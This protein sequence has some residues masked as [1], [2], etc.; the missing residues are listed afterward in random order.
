MVTKSKI[1]S[2]KLMKQ[3][4]KDALE[5]ALEEDDLYVEEVKGEHFVGN[6]HGLTLAGLPKRILELEQQ[7]T[8]FTSHRAKVASLEDHVGSL[9]TSIEA[10]KLLRNR[11][12]STFKRDK[13]LVNATEA[14]RKIIAEGNGWAHG[15]DVVVDALLYQGTEGRRDRLAF[16]KL[17]GI[18]P[19]D[20]RVISYQPTIDILNLHAGVIAS[21][22]KTGSDEFYARF[23]EFVK[24]LKESNY[25]KGYLEGNA[26][27]MT[28]AY[29]SFLNCIR[30]GVKRADAVGASD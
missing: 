29:W 18:M 22:H 3:D 20:I 4:A 13:G 25:K 17:Y 10:Y 6:R 30:N 28:R 9:T 14:D 19:G 2:E 8:E 16:E 21:K 15:G 23:S 11:F 1:G 7:A 27:D 12:I 5:Q 26:T 24:L